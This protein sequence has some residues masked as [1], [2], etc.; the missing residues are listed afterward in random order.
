MHSQVEDPISNANA[1]RRRW[2][3]KEGRLLILY[4]AVLSGDW[5]AAEPVLRLDKSAA[6]LSITKVEDT[7][8]HLAALTKQTA[9]AHMLVKYLDEGDLEIKNNYGNTA[10]FCAAVSGDVEI[11]KV[12]YEKYNTLPTIRNRF[13]IS[14]IQEAAALGNKKMIEYLYEITPLKHFE[15][16][17]RMNILAA[18]INT[19]TN[20]LAAPHP[21]NVEEV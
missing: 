19:G 6:C 8:L 4:K 2:G 13:G 17:E 18:T 7:P 12:V 15:D 1:Q 16:E 3:E 20:I 10:F 5:N 9:I 21:R 14:P 11:A